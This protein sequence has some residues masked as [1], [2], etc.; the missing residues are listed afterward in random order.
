MIFFDNN[1]FQP[2]TFLNELLVYVSMYLKLSH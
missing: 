1:V 2:V